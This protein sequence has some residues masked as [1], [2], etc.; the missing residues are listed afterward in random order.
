MTGEP[1][2]FRER[3][4]FHL[5]LN[6]RR[7]P[8]QGPRVLALKPFHHFSKV[9]QTLLVNFEIVI[10]PGQ[11]RSPRPI[12]PVDTVWNS[13]SLHQE[14]IFHYF[15]IKRPG[16]RRA[17]VILR[18]LRMF[19]PPAPGREHPLRRHERRAGI[20]SMLAHQ[21]RR[22]TRGVDFHFER[23]AFKF[24]LDA[25]GI[26]GSKIKNT[27]PGSFDKDRVAAR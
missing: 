11:A 8:E 5:P 24:D 17:V 4:F 13:V 3:F 2:T 18:A 26:G 7:D 16:H 19:V 10:A 12:D 27:R 1:V 21:R 15:R 9:W 6:K 25:A 20:Q 23:R 14:H 22:I